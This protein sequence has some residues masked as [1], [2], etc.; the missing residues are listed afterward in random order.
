MG[1]SVMTQLS[2]GTAEKSHFERNLLSVGG[3]D[4]SLEFMNTNPITSRPDMIPFRFEA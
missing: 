4:Q 2:N 3:I 1:K